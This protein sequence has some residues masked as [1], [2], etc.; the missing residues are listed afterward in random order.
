M[1]GAGECAC[2]SSA[3]LTVLLLTAGAVAQG[4]PA[5]P[6][7]YIVPF[8]PGGGQD[9]VARALAPRLS[10]ALGQPVLV[11]NATVAMR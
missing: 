4:Y 6:I 9:L 3:A 5:R 2:R 1:T 11:D 8:P 10:E 7:R